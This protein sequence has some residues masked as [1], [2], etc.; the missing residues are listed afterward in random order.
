MDSSCECLKE[1]CMAISYGVK[2]IELIFSHS[3]S[4]SDHILIYF[5]AEIGVYRDFFFGLLQISAKPAGVVHS[6]TSNTESHENR[7]LAHQAA[8]FTYTQGNHPQTLQDW[9]LARLL[10]IGSAKSATGHGILVES[11]SIV[12]DRRYVS[13]SHYWGSKPVQSLS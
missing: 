11:A 7:S 5:Q 1:L 4:N 8:N 6:P 13:L 3:I 10:D 12:P 2:I 9:M